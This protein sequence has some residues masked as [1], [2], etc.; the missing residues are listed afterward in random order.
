MCYH[1]GM[2]KPEKTVPESPVE[3]AFA[4][5]VRLSTW[6]LFFERLWPRLWILLGLAA[7]FATLSLAGVWSTMPHV[8]H[9]LILAGLAAAGL[10]AIVFAARVPWPNREDAVRRIERR[11][12]VAH[13]PASSY[14]DTPPTMGLRMPRFR[15]LFTCGRR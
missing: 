4:R 5:K 8:L 10:A 14:E 6:A 3:R 13:R 11:S 15:L 1:L 2:E 12:G 9:G 7:A